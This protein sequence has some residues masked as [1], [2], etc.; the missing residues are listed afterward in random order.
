VV[1]SGAVAARW[2]RRRVVVS[3]S[4]LACTIAYT[5]R[6]NISVAAVAMQERFG[7][8]QTQ[9]GL[10]LSAFFV[11]YLSFMFVAGLLATRYGGKRVL[12][13][14]VV[15]WSAFTLLTPLAASAS[16]TI[17]I[18]TRICMGIGEAGMMPAAYAIF[19]RWTPLSERAR[20]V[21]RFL[22]GVPVGTVVGLIGAGWLVQRYGW[23]M[24][25]YAFGVVGLVW[26]FF[27]FREVTDDPASDAR[28]DD[29]E[30]ALLTTGAA[31]SGT[32]S[33]A[34]SYRWLMRMPVW[35]IVIG[36]FATMWDLYVLL[37]WLP[38]YFREVQKLSI[39]NAGLYAAAPWMA[40][41]VTTNVAASVS[42][43]MIKR[44]ASVTAVRRW[45]Q[46]GGLVVCAAFLLATRGRT[47]RVWRSRCC[48]PRRVRSGAPGA[49]TRRAFS[50]SLHAAVRCSSA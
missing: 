39:A 49:D 10:V 17:L 40:M 8:S 38:S 50:M 18:A 33:S 15:A 31:M 13:Y 28:V 45:M 21:A 37:S 24:A 23:P 11:G 43:A 47:R 14:S 3:L 1:S 6:V 30:R 19:G 32:A 22:S 46:C 4:A 5:D 27:W 44:G 2:P 35:A 36:Q 48:V 42:D 34:P 7:W 29:E 12:G 25:F 9:K 20:A 41:F 16:I 26:A